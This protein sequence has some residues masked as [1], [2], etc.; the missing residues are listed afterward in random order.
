MAVE[1]VVDPLEVVEEFTVGEPD[2]DGLAPERRGGKGIPGGWAW[3][4]NPASTKTAVVRTRR[5]GAKVG[6]GVII[7]FSAFPK[8]RD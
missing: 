4:E 2:R 5:P 6:R 8:I 3:A 1:V 7:M